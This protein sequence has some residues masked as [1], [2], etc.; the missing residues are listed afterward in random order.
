MTS[1]SMISRNPARSS[2]DALRLALILVGIAFLAA[3]P[4]FFYPIFLMKILCFALFAAAFN[5]LLGFT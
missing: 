5:L 3:A 1:L 4:F 2:A